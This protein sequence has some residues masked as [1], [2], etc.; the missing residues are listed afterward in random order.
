MTSISLAKNAE[1][2]LFLIKSKGPQT[3]QSCASS[4]NITSMGARQHLH[5]L[6]GK[7]LVTSY[8]ENTGTGRPKRYWRLTEKSQQHFPDAHAYLTVEIINSIQNVFGDAGVNNIISKREEKTLRDYRQALQNYTQLG[9]K[10]RK[11]TEL[12]NQEGYMAE[13]QRN[14]DGSY[15]LLENHCPICAAASHCQNFCKS[16]L[17]IF[18]TVLG[19]DVMVERQS[20]I[21]SGARRCTYLITKKN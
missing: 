3:A 5:D 1:N 10:V 4:L 19:N 13:Y 2:L 11:L 18:Q 14:N 7:G 8:D 21:V 9:T 17:Q 20:H 12:R 15:L 16:E 6:Q